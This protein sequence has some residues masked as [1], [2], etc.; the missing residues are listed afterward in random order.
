MNS[1]VKYTSRQRAHSRIVCDHMEFPATHAIRADDI[2][3]TKIV[4]KFNPVEVVEDLTFF[5]RRSSEVHNIIAVLGSNMNTH[6]E[7]RTA[8]TIYSGIFLKSLPWQR[9][10]ILRFDR[11]TIIVI[12]L[13]Y[14]VVLDSPKSYLDPTKYSRAFL[15][16][17]GASIFVPSRLVREHSPTARHNPFRKNFLSKILASIAIEST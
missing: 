5:H 10:N 7:V 12:L 2:Q 11:K 16:C 6:N 13:Y 17:R 1:R 15:R 14:R 4:F 3:R 9:I 8:S